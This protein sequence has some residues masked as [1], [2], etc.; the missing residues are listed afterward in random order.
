MKS[1]VKKG[2]ALA[3]IL[4]LLAPALVSAHTA[5]LPYWG[6]LVS[7]GPGTYEGERENPCENLCDLIHTAQHVIYFGITLALFAFAPAFF[8]WGGLMIMTAGGSPLE[9][10]EGGKKGSPERLSQ[11]KKILEGTA[12]G[13]VIVLGAFL[14]VNTFISLLGLGGSEGIQFGTVQCEL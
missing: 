1:E 6:P 4:F 11:G 14:I 12:I 2:I 3:G 5:R 7:C 9:V 10:L 13:V 8:A